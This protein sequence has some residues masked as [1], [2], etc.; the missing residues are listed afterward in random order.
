M[1]SYVDQ[2]ARPVTQQSATITAS[3]AANNFARIE[4]LLSK[5]SLLFKR[6]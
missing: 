5:V 2:S 1:R 4:I 3:T 6:E